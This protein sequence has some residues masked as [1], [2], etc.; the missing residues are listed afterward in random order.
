[1]NEYF[2]IVMSN[3]MISRKRTIVHLLCFVMSCTTVLPCYATKTTFIDN[4]S[5][6]DLIEKFPKSKVIHV[7]PE[8]YQKLSNTLKFQGYSI[9][10]KT[11]QLV[12]ANNGMEPK[13]ADSINKNGAKSDCNENSTSQQSKGEDSLQVMLDF[14]TDMMKSSKD[15]DGDKAAILFVI[16][17]T[18]VLVV[19]TLYAFKYIYDLSKG[20]RPCSRWN[21]LTIT[22]SS[23]SE[24]SNQHANFTGV[25][26]TS[27]FSEGKTDIGL[28]IE[29][30]QSDILLNETN[31]LALKGA[32]WLLGPTLRWQLN[33]RD[34]PYYF[35]MNF[36][37]GTTEHNEIGIIALANLGF[38]FSFQE[39]YQLGINWGAMNIDLSKNE[40]IISESDRYHYLYGINFGYHF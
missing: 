13:S 4:F 9:L 27:G 14:S 39:S 36:L 33:S 22:S 26:Y 19:W 1:M 18:V 17:G 21:E 8:A 38:R 15:A 30:G 24:N 40:G 37:A 25:R 3:K 31:T 5:E 12:M 28:S 20:Y 35:L 29:Y 23:M 10:E 7:S 11:N 34:A 32:Y 16:V 6:K 2:S